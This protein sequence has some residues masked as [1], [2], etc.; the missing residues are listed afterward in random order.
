MV[1]MTGQYRGTTK[2]GVE[3][4]GE[5]DAGRDTCRYVGAAGQPEP[6]T[7]RGTWDFFLSF[8]EKIALFV[9]FFFFF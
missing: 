3:G 2:P 5:S 7:G 8:L 1:K 9:V 4:C 6:R